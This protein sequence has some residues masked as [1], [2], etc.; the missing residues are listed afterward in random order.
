[1]VQVEDSVSYYKVTPVV[2]CRSIQCGLF[3]FSVLT[4][5]SFRRIAIVQLYC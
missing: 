1:M 4:F 3:I 2:Y 5:T